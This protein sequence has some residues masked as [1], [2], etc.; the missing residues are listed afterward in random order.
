MVP[1]IM[2]K[3]PPKLSKGN[4]GGVAAGGEG[5][6]VKSVPV[7]TGGGPQSELAMA[8]ASAS[9]LM[10]GRVLAES[11]A[12]AGFQ[13]GQAAQLTQF[14]N[15]IFASGERAVFGACRQVLGKMPFL[16]TWLNLKRA[17]VLD[18]LTLTGEGGRALMA[19]DPDGASWRRL[20]RDVA[21][22]YLLCDNAVVNWSVDRGLIPGLD[23]SRVALPMVLN[24]EQVEYRD[25]HAVARIKVEAAGTS[26]LSQLPR[27]E[28]ADWI[29]EQE[30]KRNQWIALGS[31]QERALGLRFGVLTTGKRGAGL[32]MPSLFGLI[33]DLCLLE[34]LRI[35][36]W[37]GAMQMRDVIRQFTKGVNIN[38]GPLAGQ[39]TYFL[40]KK[41]I[42]A[43]KAAVKDKLGAW[44]FI[45]NFDMEVKFPFL[46]PKYFDKGKYDP[47]WA[48]L[49]EWAGPLATALR[50]GAGEAGTVAMAA[51]KQEGQAHRV[52]VGGFLESIYND[53]DYHGG[54]VPEGQRVK[55]AFNP[56]SFHSVKE[57]RE[58]L[59][60]A[61]G[62]AIVSPQTAN[63]V[64][65]FDEA[66]ERA[67]IEAAHAK[68]ESYFPVFEPRQG[69]LGQAA[70][71]GNPGGE[72]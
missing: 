2:G 23:E 5:V 30:K 46:D 45:T 27:E 1:A 24:T 64:T 41:D 58:Y 60:W 70:Q 39:P 51:W 33:F 66:E 63:R 13:P 72:Q 38:Y 12:H 11:L 26:E 69:L 32:K 44:D 35:G 50:A 48:R 29:R 4:P 36:D 17:Y 54:L 68:K 3:S 25:S 49:V 42:T 56:L 21:T 28:W 16:E 47:T 34:V 10:Q 14:Q 65:G 18:G 8:Q 7:E 53:P 31:D 15:L 40:K 67:L 55:V 62:N 59:S 19:A 37:N 71:A 22:E 6:G 57:A 43:I 61:V 9:R 20:A 52:A